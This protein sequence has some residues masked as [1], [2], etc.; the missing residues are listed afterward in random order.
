MMRL[1]HL[2]KK[3]QRSSFV[4]GDFVGGIAYHYA[5]SE[6]YISA[7][8]GTK[9]DIGYLYFIIICQNILM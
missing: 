7:Q 1:L 6:S 8:D 5:R 2:E 9:F 4:Q 3:F